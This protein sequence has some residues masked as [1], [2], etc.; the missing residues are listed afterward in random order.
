[1]DILMAVVN[2]FSSTILS[3]PAWIIGFIVTIGYVLLG[4]KWYE[5]L[6][7]F[8]KASV[9]YMILSVGSSGHVIPPDHG[10][11][12][13]ALWSERHGHRPLLWQQRG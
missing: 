10:R 3:Q 5:V 13:P 8:I 6:A 7:G 2:W 12:E 4:K 1:M 9:G 11:S